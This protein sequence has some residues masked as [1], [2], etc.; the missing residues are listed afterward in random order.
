M[1]KKVSA[2]ARTYPIDGV[3]VPMPSQDFWRLYTKGSQATVFT[4]Q[5]KRRAK[6][7]KVDPKKP[8][9]KLKIQGV[10][11]DPWA[12]F[13]PD[14]DGHWSFGRWI[15]KTCPGYGFKHWRI[16]PMGR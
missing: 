11:R 9:V 13:V 1:T 16:A 6:V 5:G 4:Q 8:R 3:E 2:W 12:W 15:I 14:D 7:L 10:S